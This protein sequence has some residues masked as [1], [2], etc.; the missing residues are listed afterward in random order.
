MLPLACFHPSQTLPEEITE[1]MVLGAIPLEQ[2]L[3]QLQAWEKEGILITT[4][5]TLALPIEPGVDLTDD[6]EPVRG[7]P[8]VITDALVDQERVLVLVD[9]VH[10]DKRA[11]ACLRSSSGYT[12]RNGA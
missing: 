8:S 2:A 10:R 7:V 11:A 9:C 3:S 6:L 1:E 12:W 5:G 4:R